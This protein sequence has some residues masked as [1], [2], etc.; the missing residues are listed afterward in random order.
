MPND[1][2]EKCH[3]HPHA[4]FTN[5]GYLCDRCTDELRERQKEQALADRIEAFRRALME[6]HSQ[7]W[8]MEVISEAAHICGHV[9]VVPRAF[10]EEHR[11]IRERD[12]TE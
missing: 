6:A 11:V 12:G 9:E 10:V 5:E 4:W 8:T 1:A 7:D 2:C 3:Q